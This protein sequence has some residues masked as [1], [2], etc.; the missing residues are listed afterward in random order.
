MLDRGNDSV[1]RIAR[2]R[3]L[4]GVTRFVAGYYIVAA[5]QSSEVAALGPHK[6]FRVDEVRLIPIANP[7]FVKIPRRVAESNYVAAFHAMTSLQQDLYYSPTYDL[8]HTLQHNLLAQ[9]LRATLRRNAFTAGGSGGDPS[10]AP[11]PATAAPSPTS[12]TPPLL[13]PQCTRVAKRGMG[14]AGVTESGISNCGMFTWTAYHIEIA[15]KGTG[16]L[17]D[18]TSGSGSGDQSTTSSARRIV[19]P[20]PWFVPAIQG[21]V[22]QV[23]FSVANEVES[24]Q[25]VHDGVQLHFPDLDQAAKAAAS[26]FRPSSGIGNGSSIWESFPATAA[27]AATA[28]LTASGA[29]SAPPPNASAPPIL[30]PE[31]PSAHLEEDYEPVPVAAGHSPPTPPTLGLHKKLPPLPKPA[32]PSGSFAS[33]IGPQVQCA[34]CYGRGISPD[35]TVRLERLP[36]GFPWV[37]PY[38]SFVQ[39][40][41]SIPLIWS[42][43]NS[44][45]TPKPPIS[46]NIRDAF[47]VVASKHFNRI[48]T[49][50]GAPL[51]VFNLIKN[52][53]RV[54]R[55][56]ILG[57]DFEMCVKYLN[58]FLVEGGTSERIEY[59]HIDMSR[60]AKT[61]RVIDLL[62]ERVTKMVDEIGFFACVP[63]PY[64][65]ARL[66]SDG[67]MICARVQE[68]IIRTNCIDCLDRTNAAAFVIG[69]C[70]LE[71]QLV[72]LGTLR[73]AVLDFDTDAIQHLTV[74]YERHGDAIALQ[75]GGSALVNTMRTYR[76]RN[77]S[78]QSRDMI[79]TLKRYYNNSFTD[80]EKQ[81]A[82]DIFL[83]VFRDWDGFVMP[84]AAWEAMA[85][86][87]KATGKYTE[88]RQAL[89]ELAEEGA[90]A[91][92]ASDESDQWA[93]R[94]ELV[95][96]E[97][98]CK[99][100]GQDPTDAV[101]NGEGGKFNLKGPKKWL[102]ARNSDSH[103][104]VSGP[105]T[106]ATAMGDVAAVDRDRDDAGSTITSQGH[107]RIKSEPVVPD[108]VAP[109]PDLPTPADAISP[110]AGRAT[111]D[112][113]EPFPPFSA[114]AAAGIADGVDGTPEK[115]RKVKK[116]LIETMVEKALSLDV[117]SSMERGNLYEYPNPDA[118]HPDFEVFTR[119][120]ALAREDA[121]A[122]VSREDAMLYEA[123]VALPG[124]VGIMVA[125][126]GSACRWGSGRRVIAD[127]GC[128]V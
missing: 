62:E 75:Y 117:S 122:D 82:I 76:D 74:L 126:D 112:M 90:L 121:R 47:Y 115:P 63:E 66:R 40:R 42:Q 100:F 83:G 123:Y 108:Y 109:V 102:S 113:L 69:K 2:F 101:E 46:L 25:I 93:F 32:T 105:P 88:W 125:D 11:D 21:F 30:R 20:S 10:L 99:T 38:T 26:L 18:A 41:G 104:C 86:R 15:V 92:P 51:I 73:T 96:L 107:R 72:H 103:S 52:N 53:E 33:R 127:K 8:T 1:R 48:L 58:Q 78:T 95:T 64:V 55:E 27:P 7:L 61:G 39:H 56:S 120:C 116:K 35:G 9:A 67:D 29:T 128:D 57:D 54:K 70:A 44:A 119:T 71:R 6:L 60:E 77:L 59:H 16:V 97:D 111:P 12:S 65:R 85:E 3:A 81:D 4:I 23:Q 17:D 50:Y 87:A 84:N 13:C 24:E 89:P 14:S 110:A 49:H 80:A 5:V 124:K 106:G 98:I 22:G 31:S 118:A 91:D 114:K 37:P 45:M 68:G 79:E 94:N 19:P 43:D 36:V 28:N 34:F